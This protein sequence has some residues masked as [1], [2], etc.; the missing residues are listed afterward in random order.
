MRI[1][2]VGLSG[3]VGRVHRLNSTLCGN[4]MRVYQ[5]FTQDPCS[6]SFAGLPPNQTGTPRR[7]RTPVIPKITISPANKRRIIAAVVIFAVIVAVFI[8]AQFW[9]NWWWFS[10]MGYRSVLLRR[11]LL[12]VAAFLVVALI[13][14]GI[15]GGSASL[16]FRRTRQEASRSTF[17]RFANRL[18]F[19][20]AVA[21]SVVTGLVLAWWTASKWETFALWWNGRSMGINDPIYNRDVSFYL[22]A[23]PALDLIWKVAA[24]ATVIAFILTAF[25]Y[26]I[27][28]GLNLRNVGKLPVT[29]FRHLLALIG[30]LLLLG[31]IWFYLDNYHLVYST[32]GA[33]YGVSYTDDHAIRI[34]NWVAI[35]A[36]IVAGAAC[37]GS[38]RVPKRREA[39]LAAIVVVF[40]SIGVQGLLPLVV[41]QAIV[42]PDELN[43]ERSYIA[44]NIAM[45]T[46]R[47][48]PG[49]CPGRRVG[50][51]WHDH[52]A[53]HCGEPRAALECA[54]LGLPGRADDLPG[55]DLV[56]TVLPVPR[57]RH[58]SLR[59]QRLEQ[60]SS[61]LSEGAQPGWAAVECADLD[62]P[63]ACLHPWLR[64]WSSVRS[65][66][67]TRSGLPVFT[68]SQIPPNGSGPFTI[69]YPEIYYGEADLGWVIV[70][71]KVAGVF[72][73]TGG[74]PD[75]I[76][77]P[78]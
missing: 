4:A 30:V 44:N 43:K 65:I 73:A 57:R 45:T 23:L 1:G 62:Q 51:H 74:R 26:L 17:V 37:I 27:R 28:L 55:T 69:T 12:Q 41:K 6:S 16:A 54:A 10:S 60:T 53:G 7:P 3:R 67:A 24:I 52:L 22:F 31:A 35:V 59:D 14:F 42:E 58:R 71:T 77:D 72:S 68:V 11:A 56:R 32:R 36:L 49:R 34:A 9:M 29:A 61:G 40:L 2:V 39:F 15:V 48:R 46:L 63:A 5:E 19:W 18:L 47:V 75:H 38:R 66:E 76:A 50:R 70:G 64:R 21:A 78:G 13:G 8:S 25:I 33:A 20:I